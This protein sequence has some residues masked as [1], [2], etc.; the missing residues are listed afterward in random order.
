MGAPNFSLKLSARKQ[1]PLDFTGLLPE[2]GQNQPH[3]LS[4]RDW[5]SA[6]A[7]RMWRPDALIAA[8][9]HYYPGLSFVSPGEFQQWFARL[10]AAGGMADFPDE[11]RQN[12]ALLT[13][14]L[15]L[16]LYILLEA[17]LD[18]V[19]KG[20]R[21]GPLG[22]IIVGEVMFRAL[23]EAE[24]VQSPLLPAT[25]QALGEDAWRSINGVKTMPDLIELVRDWAGLSDCPRMPFIAAPTPPK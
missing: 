19:A 6:A 10:S 1:M 20:Q 22:S 8:I 18:P 4:V 23:A 25:E 14:D 15:P 11:I 13:D 7:A 17:E 2:V 24:A 5:L 21:L 9:R 12:S 3:N 16:P